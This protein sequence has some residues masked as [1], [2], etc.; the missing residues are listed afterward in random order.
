MQWMLKQIAQVEKTSSGPE[1][2]Y[3]SFVKQVV[4][5]RNAM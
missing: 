2:T 3:W 4:T 5:K 1:K